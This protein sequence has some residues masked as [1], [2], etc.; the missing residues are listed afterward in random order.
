MVD[1][2][3]L[4][5][6]PARDEVGT[7]IVTMN[8]TPDQLRFDIYYRNDTEN[9]RHAIV[10]KG[11]DSHLVV[12]YTPNTQKGDKVTAPI[13]WLP[14]NVLSILSHAIQDTSAHKVYRKALFRLL[15][16][17][18]KVDSFKTLVEPEKAISEAMFPMCQ[19]I[20]LNSYKTFGDI[21]K[22]EHEEYLQALRQPTA[23]AM[24]KKLFGQKR[25][26][27]DLVKALANANSIEFLAF[28]FS[29]KREIPVDWFINILR[30]NPTLSSL[31]DEFDYDALKEFYDSM[32]DKQFRK[33][34][35]CLMEE[36]FI[37]LQSIMD[38]VPQFRE[39]LED[40]EMERLNSVRDIKFRTLEEFHYWV[41]KHHE[42]TDKERKRREMIK[43]HGG[44]IKGNRWYDMIKDIDFSGAPYEVVI[45]Q[46]AYELV[47]WG[48]TMNN[49]I[50]SY[51]SRAKDSESDLYVALKDKNGTMKANILISNQ[52]VRQ[53]Y[54]KRNSQV[55]D[56][57]AYDF[58]M[59]LVLGGL[60]TRESDL[61]GR[62]FDRLKSA[63]GAN[64]LNGILED[65]RNLGVPVND[66]I[67][68]RTIND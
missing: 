57:L 46:Y 40:E 4:Y 25:Y 59:R 56:K 36:D 61:F 24:A 1:N 45:P 26:R 55:D 16:R 64:T 42:A 34:C 38:M 15:R 7:S 28:M 13:N 31:P 53:F 3:L 35:R 50:G 17:Y 44:E 65:Y 10:L 22:S 37:P 29:L 32:S 11:T 51:A 20:P 21:H 18:T 14:V 27:K 62:H 23:Q 48:G 9:Y 33:F 5:N 39:C 47:E 60:I 30:N 12:H 66:Y 6:G 19:T 49:C 52:N 58:N 8:E 43:R 41:G 54:A 68:L 2:L 67:S 63:T